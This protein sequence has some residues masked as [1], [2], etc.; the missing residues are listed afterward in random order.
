[1]FT[2]EQMA[3]LL[4]FSLPGMPRYEYIDW[5]S[6]CRAYQGIVISPYFWSR[7]MG[8]MW[9]YSWDCASGVIWDADAIESVGPSQ[10]TEIMERRAREQRMRRSKALIKQR[11]R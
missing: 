9:Y 10:R 7:R 1:M 4:S 2:S 3:T 11:G 5:A 8:P 6:V